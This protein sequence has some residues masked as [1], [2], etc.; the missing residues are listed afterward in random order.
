MSVVQKVSSKKQSDM[1]NGVLIAGGFALLFFGADFLVKGSVRLSLRCGISSLIIGLTVLA[2]G[3]STPELFV[4]LRA[5]LHG[6]GDI[7]MG[8]IIGSNIFNI[9]FILGL[10]AVLQPIKITSPLIMQDIPV[11]IG[12]TILF[13]VMSRNF[14]LQ[15]VEG[16]ILF[17]ILIIYI[18]MTVR[19]AGQSD[20]PELTEEME[21]RLPARGGSM[22]MNLIWV[23]GGITLLV[24]GSNLLLKGAI[25]I[26][27]EA[28]VSQAVIGLTLVAAGT[29][30]PELSTSVMA[31]FKKE[32]DLAVSNIVGSNIFNVLCI[33]G[34]NPL[35]RPL[36]FSDMEQM[37]L[38]VMTIM[39][40]ILLPLSLTGLRIG[41]R[42]GSLLLGSY[43]A[44]LYYIWPHAH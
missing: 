24:M 3:T 31:A 39:A 40:V 10:A 26:A 25:N 8:N 4:S 38:I 7:A 12:A 42:E 13:V 43:G 27:V 33:G 22:V 21:R 5:N 18:V 32:S 44:Y 34:L 16:A 17:G 36:Q 14:S 15:R 2:F 41:R 9:A 1:L 30:L 29:S 35:I 6:N 20:E 37:D 28:G 19:V 11:M 23:A